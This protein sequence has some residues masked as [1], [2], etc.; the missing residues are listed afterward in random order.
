MVWGAKPRGR[1]AT[2]KKRKRVVVEKGV[3]VAEKLG[4]HLPPPVPEN[5]A[6]QGKQTGEDREHPGATLREADPEKKSQEGVPDNCG[7]ETL[8]HRIERGEGKAFATPVV[9]AE[10]KLVGDLARLAVVFCF[11]DDTAKAVDDQKCSGSE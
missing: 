2:E 10:P 5:K 6:N 7:D 8:Q 4:E 3:S 1:G 9:I 11:A